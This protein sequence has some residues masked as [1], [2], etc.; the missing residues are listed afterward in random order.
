M[1][2]ALVCRE[3]LG[4]EDHPDLRLEVEGPIFTTLIDPLPFH[5]VVLT[6]K[7]LDEQMHPAMLVGISERRAVVEAAGNLARHANLMLRL[8]VESDAE[9]PEELYAKVVQ[10][11]D[12]SSKRYVIHFTSIPPKMRAWLR[13]LA[14]LVNSP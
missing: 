2:E 8:Q 6:D 11:L 3:L 5:Y 4:H 1:R 10:L 9:K 14:G 13:R 7:H 12:E